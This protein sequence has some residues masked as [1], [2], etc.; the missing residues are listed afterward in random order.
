MVVLWWKTRG[1]Q[2]YLRIQNLNL[3]TA[4]RLSQVESFG[5]NWTLKAAA[6]DQMAE[7]KSKISATKTMWKI[8][9]GNSVS[10]EN[11]K[12]QSFWLEKRHQ[13]VDFPVS[14]A[15]VYVLCI[16]DTYTYNVCNT[17]AHTLDTSAKSIK[18]SFFRRGAWVAWEAELGSRRH[19]KHFKCRRFACVSIYV[20]IIHIQIL[21]MFLHILVYNYIYMINILNIYIY[22]IHVQTYTISIISKMYPREKGQFSCFFCAWTA[23]LYAIYLF[24]WF[25]FKDCWYYAVLLR[26][27]WCTVHIYIYIYMYMYMYI[28]GKHTYYICTYI[29]ILSN[30]HL[31]SWKS[32]LVAPSAGRFGHHQETTE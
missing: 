10:M 24:S 27:V 2:T 26:I 23:Y 32:I 25:I 3:R 11:I 15:A 30:I 16:Y 20:Y 19:A 5:N 13:M 6:P 17:C 21:C 1:K 8:P 18:N 7:A 31:T 14:H 28:H 9:S 4:Q 12:H 22:I 29:Q